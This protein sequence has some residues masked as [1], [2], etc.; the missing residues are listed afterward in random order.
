MKSINNKYTTDFLGA[1]FLF[2][3]VI[4]GITYG[5]SYAAGPIILGIIFLVSRFIFSQKQKMKRYQVIFFFASFIF[6]ILSVYVATR[7]AESRL[8][9]STAI[10]IAATIFCLIFSKL[11]EI[12][13]RTFLVFGFFIFG[14]A[15]FYNWQA[16]GL[17][18]PCI[19][20]FAL[21]LLLKKISEPEEV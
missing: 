21:Q 11:Q 16:W 14:A 19:S 4:M 8:Q 12:N 20:M 13:L 18:I 7:V 1:V 9:I 2:V 5:S 10:P 17:A 6:A 3:G 15:G